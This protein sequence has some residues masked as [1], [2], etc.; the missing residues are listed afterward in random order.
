MG[1]TG[2]LV[3]AILIPAPYASQKSPLAT[4]RRSLAFSS[5]FNSARFTSVSTFALRSRTESS[6]AFTLLWLN[7]SASDK[8]RGSTKV[9]ILTVR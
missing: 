4:F 9:F 5:M 2:D 6:L 1:A 3:G 7:G 8:A